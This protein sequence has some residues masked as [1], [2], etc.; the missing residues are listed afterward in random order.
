ML[1]TEAQGCNRLMWLCSL[2][3][4][5][6]LYRGIGESLSRAAEIGQATNKVFLDLR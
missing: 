6:L 4:T 2:S 3:M 1:T 5:H